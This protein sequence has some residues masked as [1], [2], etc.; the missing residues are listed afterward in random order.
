MYKSLYNRVVFDLV[1]EPR[2]PILIR[3]GTSTTDPSRP[4]LEC[5]RTHH[6]LIDETVFIP[7]SSMKGVIRSQA[8]RILRTMG[9]WCCD[10]LDLRSG[11]QKEVG[12]KDENVGAKSYNQA[13]PACRM[14]GSTRVAGRV[15]IPDMFPWPE[16]ATATQIVE[17]AKQAN[18]TERRTGVAIDR[19]TGGAKHGA[20][21]ELEV[22]TRGEFHTRLSMKNF[23][24]WQLALLGFILRDLDEGQVH[25]GSGKSR[26]LGNVKLDL[27]SLR[28][29]IAANQATGD[30]IPGIGEMSG[31]KDLYRFSAS[32]RIQIPAQLKRITSTNPFYVMYQASGWEDCLA[33][34]AECARTPWQQAMIQFKRKEGTN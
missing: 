10:P 11:C 5:I 9:M 28:I 7:G 32:D 2:G 22:V 20:L 34:L 13:C 31:E 21:Y 19:K 1:L 29:E 27:R 26:G 14:F 3:S 6:P 4:D 17:Y 12:K 16:N 33:V 15:M 30:T 18:Q 25:I 23:Q 8:E 24:L